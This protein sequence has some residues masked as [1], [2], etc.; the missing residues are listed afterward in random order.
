MIRDRSKVAQETQKELAIQPGRL[1]I[2]A[3]LP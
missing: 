3:V 1:T 2:Q